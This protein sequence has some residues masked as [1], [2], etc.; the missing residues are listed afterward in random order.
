MSSGRRQMQGIS[1]ILQH[2][3]AKVKV[4]QNKEGHEYSISETL[5]EVT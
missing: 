2:S 1:P 5:S 3:N 4:G